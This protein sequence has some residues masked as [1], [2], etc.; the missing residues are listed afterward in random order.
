MDFS[1]WVPPEVKL[2]ILL[3]FAVIIWAGYHIGT[4][5]AAH[6]SVGLH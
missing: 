1:G 3:I 2:L 5:I 6:V 4:W